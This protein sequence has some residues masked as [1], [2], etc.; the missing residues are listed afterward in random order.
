MVIEQLQQLDQRERRFGLAGFIAGEGVH[1]ATEDHGRFLL[2]E[3]EFSAH[4]GDEGGGGVIG[5]GGGSGGL[6]HGPYPNAKG[7]RQPPR[8]GK[9]NKEY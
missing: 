3:R 9:T 7:C 6:S 5:K 4:P 1:P 2:A 8:I